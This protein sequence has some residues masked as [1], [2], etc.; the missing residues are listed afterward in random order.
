MTSLAPLMQYLVK[1]L[2]FK[3]VDEGDKSSFS[4]FRTVVLHYLLYREIE[5]CTVIIAWNEYLLQRN[6]CN[7]Y[8]VFI[9]RN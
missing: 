3:F 5:T 8:T 6:L 4:N 1:P 2:N 9:I 7:H